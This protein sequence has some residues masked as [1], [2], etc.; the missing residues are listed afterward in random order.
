MKITYKKTW[1]VNCFQVSDLTVDSC[2]KVVWGHHT[3][4]AISLLHIGP[5][6]W[7]SHHEWIKYVNFS[8][9]QLHESPY[10]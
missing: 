1:A 5:W 10:I 7:N 9:L 2:F 6:V 4:T 3:K 8:L